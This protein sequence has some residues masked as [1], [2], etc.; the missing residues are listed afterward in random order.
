MV[1]LE[2]C[3]GGVDQPLLDLRKV[4][5]LEVGDPDDIH[6]R[7]IGQEYGRGIGR[8]IGIPRVLGILSAT[9]TGDGQDR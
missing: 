3:G 9:E 7:G 6:G 2:I 8:N 5:G 4:H 1:E